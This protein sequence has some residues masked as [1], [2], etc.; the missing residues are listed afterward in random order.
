MSKV[1]AVIIDPAHFN[2][3]VSWFKENTLGNGIS[4][5]TRMS[6]IPLEYP[7]SLCYITRN[8]EYTTIIRIKAD[9]ELDYT[10]TGL[11][12]VFGD[13]ETKV[14]FENHIK[15]LE[16]KRKINLV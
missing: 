2:D 15:T 4:V 3:L 14:G 6:S 12:M 7:Y 11:R 9:F 13:D 10:S 8:G 5:E 16:R 1:G